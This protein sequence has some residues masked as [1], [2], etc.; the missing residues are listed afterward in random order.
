MEINKKLLELR[1][2]KNL[3]QE[4]L[5]ELLD[6]TRQT[7]SKWETGQSVPDLDKIPLIC[8]IYGISADELISGKT[9]TTVVKNHDNY[10][11]NKAMAITISILLYFVAVAWIMVCIPVFNM[12]PIISTA[13]FMIIIG[14]ATCIIVYSSIIN[15][16]NKDTN[17]NNPKSK[18]LKQ[19]KAIISLVIVI[20]Y[21]LVSFM[22]Q[23][24]HI[25]WILFIVL[26]LLEEIVKL[27]F[28]LK[29]G[30]DEE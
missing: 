15:K 29:D 9:K 28:V 4:R 27:I 11:N 26:G 3:S 23:A 18:L 30:K 25:T 8:D 2:A 10:K 17:F 1:K 7:V 16:K 6:V 5:A 14:I 13:I 24:W 19:V 20:I 21:F 22:T 12:D